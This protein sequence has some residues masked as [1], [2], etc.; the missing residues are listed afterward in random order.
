MSLQLIIGSSGF[1]KSYR[2]YQD[3]IR[4]SMEHPEKKYLILVP[5]Q[6]T[7]Q[8]QKNLVALHPAHGIMNIDVLS[9]Q[10][11]A[12]HVFDEVGGSSRMVLEDTGKN[13]VLRRLA[14]QNKEKLKVLGGRLE[15]MGYISEMK[16]ILSELAQY[17]VNGRMLEEAAGQAEDNRMLQDKL[18]D[19]GLLQEEFRKYREGSCMPWARWDSPMRSPPESARQ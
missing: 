2:M 9:F 4:E 1:G 7:L 5:E 12:Y 14:Q 17:N 15:R 13:L 16:S 3:I 6:F 10:R 19:I 8:T 18:Y 11:L